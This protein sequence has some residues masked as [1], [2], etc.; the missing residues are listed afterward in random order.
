MELLK[1]EDDD[2]EKLAIKVT[3][4]SQSKQLG[5][6]MWQGAV[7]LALWVRQ[8]LPDVE[9]EPVINDILK[10]CNLN[11]VPRKVK[12]KRL[13]AFGSESP[14]NHIGRHLCLLWDDPNIRI[15]E[16]ILNPAKL[17]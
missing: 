9:N 2:D 15:P 14:E 13:D 5:T 1:D 11:E 10:D 8:E 4:F 16:Q 12:N 17:K 7:P 6:I 3:Q